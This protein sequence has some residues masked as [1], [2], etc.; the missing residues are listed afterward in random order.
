ML[1]TQS[2]NTSPE[3]AEIVPCEHCGNSFTRHV[4]GKP[5][6]FCSAKCRQA[7]HTNKREADKA[8]LETIKQRGTLL[9]LHSNSAD[10]KTSLEPTGEDFDWL[11]DDSVVLHEQPE[12][13]VYFNSKGAL[14]IRQR[15]GWNQDNDPYVLICPQN[16]GDFIDKL[17]ELAGIPC[18]GGKPA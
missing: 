18:V 9:T 2:D 3:S 15:A 13:A 11:N 6:R 7:F 8:A 4:G 14:V 17:T 16:I 12:T 1:D 5:Q 10:P